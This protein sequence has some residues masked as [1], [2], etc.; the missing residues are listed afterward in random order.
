LE[1]I[2]T[3]ARNVCVLNRSDRFSSPMDAVEKHT[4]KSRPMAAFFR[5]LAEVLYLT[6]ID[7]AE[8]RPEI[9]STQE[10]IYP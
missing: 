1:S 4:T 7:H 5:S 8:A 6:V 10:R 9:A 3:L 2:A